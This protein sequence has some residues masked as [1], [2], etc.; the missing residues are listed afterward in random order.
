MVFVADTQIE[1]M[2][3]NLESVENLRTNL[4]EQGYDLNS[5]PYVVQYNKRD[6]PNVGHR[7]GAPPARST[8]AASPSS[9]PSPPPAWAC[10]TR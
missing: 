8:R 10:S 6:L 1:R 4:A 9:R 5:I 3:A 7:R 2:E